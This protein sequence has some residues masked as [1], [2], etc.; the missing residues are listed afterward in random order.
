TTAE[1]V[2][3][4]EGYVDVRPLSALPVKGLV[5]PVPA[6]EVI[7]AGAARTRLQAAAR[8]GL[9]SFVNRVLEMEQLRSAQ[10]LAEA[11]HAQVAAVVAESGV[12]KSRLLHE[13]LHS[14]HTAGWLVLQSA[15]PSYGRTISYLPVIELLRQYFG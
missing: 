7:G 14:P 10:Q 5:E 8:R 9:K 2:Q 15:P 6:Y 3:L 11:G 4:A 12:G 1:T 13:F